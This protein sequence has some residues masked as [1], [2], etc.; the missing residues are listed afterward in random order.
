M[1]ERHGLLPFKPLQFHPLADIFPLLEGREFDELVE[2]IRLH[3][4]HEQIVLHDDKILDGRNRYRAC[5]E[6][7]VAPQFK[8]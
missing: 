1:T 7:G 8:S 2:D 6:V 4:L 3:G 5:Q